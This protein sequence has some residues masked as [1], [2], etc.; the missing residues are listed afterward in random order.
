MSVLLTKKKNDVN[1][2]DSISMFPWEELTIL[3]QTVKFR[4]VFMCKQFACYNES[5]IELLL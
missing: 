3:Q 1:I 2:Y 5:I 4:V